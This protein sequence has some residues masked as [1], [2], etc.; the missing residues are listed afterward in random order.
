MDD[1]SSELIQNECLAIRM[2]KSKILIF[3]TFL[4]IYLF[5]PNITHCYILYLI[6]IYSSK[7]QKWVFEYTMVF[8]FIVFI[9]R[10]IYL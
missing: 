10:W 7:F 6:W 9:I 2:N 1:Y 8:I 3:M 4:F 5:L